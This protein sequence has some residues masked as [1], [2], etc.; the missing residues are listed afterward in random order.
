MAYD[1]GHMSF[2]E[3]LRR[4][5]FP[6]A[7]GKTHSAPIQYISIR[8]SAV[9]DLPAALRA[10]GCKKP[11]VVCDE[12]TRLAAANRAAE[13]LE[14]AG[15]AYTLYEIPTEGGDRIKPG[16]WELGSMTMHFDPSCDVVLAVGGG[17][18]NDL[19]KVL[20]HASGRPSAVLGT[21][22]SMDGFASNSSSMEINHVKMTLYN[23]S[24]AAILCDT[25]IM[26]KAPMRNLWAGFGDM[27]AKYISVCEWRI[28]AIVTG[29][30]YCEAVA[31]MMRAALA[32]IVAAAPR[33]PE[34]DPDAI[35]AIAEG[36]VLA[37]MAMAFAEVSRPASGLEHYFSHVW[38]MLALERSLPYDLHGIQVGVGT[39]LSL[40]ILKRLASMQPGRAQAESA[41]RAFDSEKW[42][43]EIN[44]VFGKTAPEIFAIEEKA[45]K[46]DPARHAGRLE[47]ILAHWN[48]IQAIIAEELP[49]EN[50]LFQIMRAL[51]MPMLP[52]DIGISEQD[53]ID[54]F[55]HSRDIRD[56][57]L[58]S[59][60]LWD[61]G[62]TD[63][64]ASWLR[65]IL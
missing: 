10:I 45:H 34:R 29:E 7:C 12:N 17:V 13:V 48:E 63:E 24:P 39:V 11:F 42:A 9:D 3:L 61:L 27:I 65:G 51:G 28:S 60:L 1:F 23:A 4:G 53:T 41:M 62:L 49:D 20:A 64:F 59:S 40:Q 16:E 14:A 47:K 19:C 38:E 32:R 56:K 58:T 54:A 44:R 25:E 5:G 46:N 55:V 21:S 26:A 36:L 15:F 31:D 8:R 52:K 6:C 50:A 18:I 43:A 37:G 33:I 35:G 2:D 57:Y 22:P 30:Y